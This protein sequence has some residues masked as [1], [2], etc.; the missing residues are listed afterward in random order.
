MPARNRRVIHFNTPFVSLVRVLGNYMVIFDFDM[1][2]IRITAPNT[3][4]MDASHGV[5][6]FRTKINALT[7]QINHRD[8]VLVSVLMLMLMLMPMP[9]VVVAA[10][11]RIPVRVAAC[12]FFVV[13]GD[14]IFISTVRIGQP[15]K[16]ALANPGATDGRGL[17]VG[18]RA[19]Y[20][21]TL[22]ASC[23]VVFCFASRGFYMPCKLVTCRC[24]QAHSA[25]ALPCDGASAHTHE[26]VGTVLR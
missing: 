22:R 25:R 26:S 8:T 9:V 14:A 24:G 7:P 21:P 3:D 12:I 1:L 15:Y 4:A 18:K 2:V 5:V 11:Q 10:M 13:T 6:E 20:A 19:F 23:L 16:A 17:A